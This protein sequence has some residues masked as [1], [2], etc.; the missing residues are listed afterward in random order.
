MVGLEQ[1]LHSE[2]LFVIDFCYLCVLVLRDLDCLSVCLLGV[3]LSFVV[4]IWRRGRE[5]FVVFIYFLIFIEEE[6]FACFFLSF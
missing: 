1:L 2:V 6:V 5:C 3:S 4:I